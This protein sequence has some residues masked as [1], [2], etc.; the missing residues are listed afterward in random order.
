M[1]R[2]TDRGAIPLGPKGRG[3]HA[4]ISDDRVH[5]RQNRTSAVAEP[6]RA[7]RHHSRAWREHSCAR[8]G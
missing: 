1:P 3:L 4:L 2:N 5:G 8:Y 6:D 7:R